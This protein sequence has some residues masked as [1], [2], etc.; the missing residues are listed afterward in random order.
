MAKKFSELDLLNREL[1]DDSDIL[2]ATD[3]SDILSRRLTFGD[4]KSYVAS[5]LFEDELLTP[6]QVIEALNPFEDEEGSGKNGLNSSKLFFT[7]T[8]LVV[9]EGSPAN[10]APEPVTTT[11]YE[12]GEYFLDWD[13]FQNTPVIATD[14]A[15]LD[16]TA[17]YTSYNPETNRLEYV[18]IVDGEVT[19]RESFNT[20]NVPQGDINKYFSENL[21]DTLLSQKFAALLQQESTVFYD[22]SNNDNLIKCSAQLSNFVSDQAN[23]LVN[24]EFA[25][26]FNKGQVIRVYGANVDNSSLVNKTFSISQVSPN[27][28]ETTGPVTHTI[29]YKIAE[30]DLTNGNISDSG[31]E[32]AIVVASRVDPLNGDVDQR[33]ILDQFDDNYNIGVRITGTSPSKAVL[34]YRK[35]QSPTL[36]GQFR[37]YAVLGPKDLETGTYVDY[38]TYDYV[39]WGPKNSVDNTF[40]SQIHVPLSPPESP[41]HGWVDV[42]VTEAD[43]AARTLTFEP[44]IYGDINRTV[45]ISHNDTQIIQDTILDF[46]ARGRSAL[47]LN[48]HIYVSAALAIPDD[49]TLRGTPGVSQI[50]KLPWSSHFYTTPTNVMVTLT[51]TGTKNVSVQDVI[52]DGSAEYQAL[53]EDDGNPGNNYAIDFRNGTDRCSLINTRVRNLIGGGVFSEQGSDLR[54][55]LCEFSDQLP[56][57]R[58]DWSPVRATESSNL[59]ITNSRFVNFTDSLDVSVSSRGLVTN[60][61]VSNCGSGILVYGSSFLITNP[62]VILGPSNELLQSPD[63]LNS[64]FDSVNIRLAEGELYESDVYRYQENGVDYDLTAE[65][66]RLDFMLFL[67][68][69]NEFGEEN[70]YYTINGINGQDSTQYLTPV[71]DVNLNGEEGLF[72]F[73]ITAE[74]VTTLKNTYEFNAMQAQNPNH[75]GVVYAAILTVENEAGTISDFAD[76]SADNDYTYEVNITNYENLALGDM[77]YL[78]GHN[79][80]A[81]GGTDISIYGK[82][83]GIIEDTISGTLRVSIEY[84]PTAIITPGNINTGTLYL[85]KNKTIVRGRVL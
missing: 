30:M 54:I 16:N 49:F 52:L 12:S 82:I 68:E 25:A 67:L 21:F 79:G 22:G 37:L 76:V 43:V 51:P 35:V 55:N 75:V 15:D 1:F 19:A 40:S 20:D 50:K 31:Q 10:T 42:T 59:M 29:T 66:G 73:K 60:N 24:V 9:P 33:P 63:A 69:K 64:I 58:Y 34:L 8:D 72:K 27:L 39:E 57:D 81:L 46:R 83:V 18:T 2:A 80:F 71:Y 77:V 65:N 26:Q 48:D 5:N 23:K 70:L 28:L 56:T 3:V 11:G 61:V 14:L 13:N 44:P 84:D 78:L 45:N 85:L 53:V 4:L 32:A 6:T 36:E 38:G 7:R 62:N 74:N 41:T 47:T 17:G